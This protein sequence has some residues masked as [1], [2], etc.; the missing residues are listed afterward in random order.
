[1]G[2]DWEH[3]FEG[4]GSQVKP[5]CSVRNVP[6]VLRGQRKHVASGPGFSAKQKG[7]NYKAERGHILYAIL[8]LETRVPRE[9][10]EKIRLNMLS[11]SLSNA[12]ILRRFPVKKN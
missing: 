2:K 8:H 6:P 12:V 1:M 5:H 4:K 9:R 3:V 11:A 7:S 10:Q